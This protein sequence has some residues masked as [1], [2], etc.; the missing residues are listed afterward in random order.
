VC[1]GLLFAEPGQAEQS[2]V[3]SGAG[4]EEKKIEEREPP[5]ASEKRKDARSFWGGERFFAGT[6][7]GRQGKR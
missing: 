3:V 7:S 1:F 5:S 6:R 4:C 2:G